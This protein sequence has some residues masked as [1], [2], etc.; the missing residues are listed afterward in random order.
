MVLSDDLVLME[1]DTLVLSG[2]AD[3]LEQAESMLLKASF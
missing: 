2:K 3:T 1:G